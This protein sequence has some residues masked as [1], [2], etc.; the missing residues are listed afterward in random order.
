MTPATTS[1]T[2]CKRI[3]RGSRGGYAQEGIFS[4]MKKKKKKGGDVMILKGFEVRWGKFFSN[5]EIQE[6]YPGSTASGTVQIFQSEQRMRD[7]HH[8]TW[9]LGFRYVLVPWSP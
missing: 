2:W 9:A 7:T 4:R 3:V 1:V 5:Q 6:T 8:H